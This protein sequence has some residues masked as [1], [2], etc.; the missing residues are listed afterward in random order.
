MPNLDAA[1]NLDKG[2]WRARVKAMRV[3]PPP[4]NCYSE[5][6]H[7]VE[8]WPIEFELIR[9]RPHNLLLILDRQQVF[10]LLNGLNSAIE[11]RL[12]SFGESSQDNSN[13]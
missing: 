9:E 2:V 7:R 5:D 10:E 4:D 3:L 1:D 8:I 6:G 13:A 11:K 12:S